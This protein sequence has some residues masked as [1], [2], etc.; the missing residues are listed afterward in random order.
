MIA[1]ISISEK[2]RKTLRFGAIAIAFYLALFIG[3]KVY[4]S[5]EARRKSY[6][7]LREEATRAQF[8]LQPYKDKVLVLKTLMESFKLDPGKLSRPLVVAETSAAIQ[9][10]ASSG[11]VML[12]QVRE[13]QSRS[14][15]GEL[16]TIQMEGAGPLLAVLGF[17]HH[18][19]SLGYPLILDSVAINSDPAKPGT[20]KISLSIILLDF[21][22][23][24]KEGTP[25]A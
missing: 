14:S 2:D 19:D 9:K 18:L 22:Q 5:M 12:A 24:K 3:F 21:E 23:W 4:Q 15:S 17:L 10:S 11:G 25:R 13:T 16:A 7:L 8:E 20:T 1:K 6:L